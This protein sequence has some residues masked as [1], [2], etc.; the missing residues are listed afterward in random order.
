MTAVSA[1]AFAQDSQPAQ[2]PYAIA[3]MA[4]DEE[5]NGNYVQVAHYPIDRVS[6]YTFSQNILRL[7][8]TDYKTQNIFFGYKE[9]G[10]LKFLYRDARILPIPYINEFVPASSNLTG[11]WE[12]VPG[13]SAYEVKVSHL[14]PTKQGEAEILDG[15]HTVAQ[16]DAEIIPSVF[17]EGLESTTSY[18]VKL[19]AVSPLGEEF[20]SPWG[21]RIN[22]FTYGDGTEHLYVTTD[23]ERPEVLTLAGRGETSITVAFNLEAGTAPVSGFDIDAD[24]KYVAD[25]IVATPY[26]KTVGDDGKVID[27]SVSY[28]LTDDEKAAGWFELNNLKPGERYDI[29]LVN[30][31]KGSMTD[32]KFNTLSISTLR[33]ATDPIV[34]EWKADSEVVEGVCDL[35][36]VLN[37]YFTGKTELGNNQVFYLEGGKDYIMSENVTVNSG[38]TLATLPSD[39]DA[40]KRARVILSYVDKSN[41]MVMTSNFMLGSV[42]TSFSNMC[43]LIQNIDFDAPDAVSY[44]QSQATGLP[45]TG[46]YLF[47]CF[48]NGEDVIIEQLH[49][50]S[51]NFSNLIRGFLRTQGSSKVEI[52]SLLVNGCLFYNCGNY[53]A[54][55]RGYAWFTTA[56]VPKHNIY[57]DFE[58]SYNTIY[59]SPRSALLT[60]GDKRY[61]FGDKK[62]DIDIS[63]NTFI[64]FN[65]VSKS[66][67]FFQFRYLPNDCH[68][69]FQRNL[70]VL[71]ADEADTRE[72]HQGGADIR[73]IG[74]NFQF[75][76]ADN[77]S[78]GCRDNHLVDDGIFTS[79][80]FS[81]T[82]NSFGAFSGSN[83]GT[84]DDLVVK[85]GSTPLRATDLFTA[86]NPPYETTTLSSGNTL[87]NASSSPDN[88][89]EALKYRDTPEVRNHEIYVKQI[90][91]PRWRF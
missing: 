17:I 35:T 78:V 82:K 19:R 72:L 41:G 50:L 71:A 62:W 4:A 79:T 23:K 25:K 39:L 42:N 86:P 36:K 26:Y 46:N 60:D 74:S 64:N 2:V 49:I 83:L 89:F 15:I 69:S 6:E 16:T 20:S 48:S 61:D 75:R 87:V 52:K 66:R 33:P 34:V 30:S 29:T 63:N 37:D 40:G 81:A 58:F 24:G 32:G 14:V 22:P 84:A 31:A 18:I 44:F 38:F 47:N 55:G 21:T 43:I 8:S 9:E 12:R 54:N 65:T 90:G 13:A 73:E 80:K 10:Y 85:V 67:T 5:F 57:E 11:V 70:I 27:E 68:I 76:F 51:C 59:N 88:I 3:S 53:D 56:G 28:T 1:G 77:Y 45:T 7:K 91:D